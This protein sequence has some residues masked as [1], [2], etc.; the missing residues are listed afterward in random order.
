MTSKVG[1]RLKRKED[2]KLLTGNGYFADDIQLPGMLHAAILRSPH[3]HAKIKKINTEEAM[4]APGVVK[5]YTGKDLEGKIGRIPS[6]WLVPDANL[7][8]AHH[9]PLAIDKTRYVGDGVAMV[10]AEDRYGVRDA[11]SLIDV[12]YEVLPAAVNQ[13]DAM[14]ED[15]PLVHDT[16]ES[17]IAFHWKAGEVSDEEINNA[18]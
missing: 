15:A 16:I 6:S 17:N 3:A 4:R 9:H 7:K 8:E 2:P 14:K 1:K 18:E 13:K 10:I 5:I 12:E 11:L